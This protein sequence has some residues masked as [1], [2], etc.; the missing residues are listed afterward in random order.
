MGLQIQ[1]RGNIGNTQRLWMKINRQRWGTAK[2]AQE[3]MK[4]REQKEQYEEAEW[5]SL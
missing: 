4:Y 2:Q 1:G 3:D 5:R